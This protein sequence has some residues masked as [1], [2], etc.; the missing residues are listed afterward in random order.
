MPHMTYV[1][2]QDMHLAVLTE[3]AQE[4]LHVLRLSSAVGCC[5]AAVYTFFIYILYCSTQRKATSTELTARS[6]CNC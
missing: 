2:L 6:T 4:R 5:F 1:S 3:Y